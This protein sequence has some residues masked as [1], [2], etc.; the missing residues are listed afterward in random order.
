MSVEDICNHPDSELLKLMTWLN[1]QEVKSCKD[2]RKLNK[3]NIFNKTPEECIEVHR[4]NKTET[5]EEKPKKKP[6][7]KKKPEPKEEKPKRD[8]KPEPKR[9]K[10]ESP[11]KRT[12]K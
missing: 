9:K 3:T 10:N 2:V 12:K 5:K 4:S 11:K 1:T 7:T 6:T 8:K